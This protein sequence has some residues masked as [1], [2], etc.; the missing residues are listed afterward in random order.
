MEEDCSEEYPT[1]YKAALPSRDM[2]P[3]KHYCQL[4]F[5]ER[6]RRRPPLS[7]ITLAL[8]T[9]DN[10]ARNQ[11]S[12]ENSGYKALPVVFPLRLPA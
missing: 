2:D 5:N 7:I 10:H 12:N 11:R 3:A 1:G 4:P 9:G 8:E 6:R